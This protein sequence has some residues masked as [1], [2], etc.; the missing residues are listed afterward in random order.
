VP[1]AAREAE[2]VHAELERT[3]PEDGRLRFCQGDFLPGQVLCD[4]SGW[5][6]I[7]FD[8]SRYADPLSEVA[9]LYAALPRELGLSGDLAERARRTYLEAYARRSGEPIDPDRW[10]WFLVLVQLLDLGKRLVKGRAAPGDAE[11]V[12]ERLCGPRDAV[13]G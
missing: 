8:D 13:L 2:A 10:H 1:A 5:S 11:A 12:L 7:D 9:A 3:A 6:V 4:P